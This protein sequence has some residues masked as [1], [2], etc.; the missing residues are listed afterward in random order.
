MVAPRLFVTVLGQWGT[1]KRIPEEEFR[2]LNIN[3]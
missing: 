1:E 2:N 3:I